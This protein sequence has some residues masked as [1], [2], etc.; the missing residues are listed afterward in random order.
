LAQA[1]HRGGQRGD[2]RRACPARILPGR[3]PA[4][5]GARA[6]PEAFARRH[7]DALRVYQIDIDEN[8]ERLQRFGIMSIPTLIL[9]REGKEVAVSTS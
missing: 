8:A 3:L 5:P 4:L 6:A 9:F 7:R 2:G 1:R